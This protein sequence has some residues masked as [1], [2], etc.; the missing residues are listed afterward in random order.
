MIYAETTRIKVTKYSMARCM[1]NSNKRGLVEMA[2]RLALEPQ[3]TIM[4]YSPD[5]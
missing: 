3:T 2:R 1:T 4:H 5:Q